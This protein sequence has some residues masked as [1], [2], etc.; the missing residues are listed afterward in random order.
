M[1][2]RRSYFSMHRFR[3]KSIITRF[4]FTAFLFCVNCLLVPIVGGLLIE[5]FVIENHQLTILAIGL[6]GGTSLAMI[7]QW[8]IAE[9]TRC[10]LCLTPVLAAKGCAKHRNARTF[11]GSHRLRV[12]LAILLRGRFHCPY[13]HEPSAMEVRKRQ[14]G[15]WPKNY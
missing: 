10:P 11:L 13:C 12:A 4:R 2:F 5:S 9:R 6:G 3:T 1:R 7:S 8:I 14:P 15:S